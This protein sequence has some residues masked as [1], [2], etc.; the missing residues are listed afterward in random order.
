MAF[1]VGKVLAAE[2]RAEVA[3]SMGA[4]ATIKDWIAISQVSSS[5]RRGTDVALIDYFYGQKAGERF[6]LFRGVRAELTFMK[7]YLKCKLCCQRDVSCC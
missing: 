2:L 3:R 6:C 4:D 5:W 1:S 7:R